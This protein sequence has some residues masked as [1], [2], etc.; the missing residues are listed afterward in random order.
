MRPQTESKARLI[1]GD[2]R[3]SPHSARLAPLQTVDDAALASVGEACQHNSNRGISTCP[4]WDPVQVWILK[5]ENHTQNASQHTA[6]WQKCESW[7]LAIA[8]KVPPMPCTQ[9]SL[10]TQIIISTWQRVH[11]PYFLSICCAE[12]YFSDFNPLGVETAE[13]ILL[14]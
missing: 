7:N 11:I 1:L 13:N 10:N 6:L 9:T 12:R 2:A 4:E 5:G 8:R 3:W 14:D